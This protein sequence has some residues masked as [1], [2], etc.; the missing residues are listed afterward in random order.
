MAPE[1]ARVG[2]VLPTDG[3]GGGP[4]STPP[5]QRRIRRDRGADPLITDTIMD[6]HE[7]ILTAIGHTP[8]VKLNKLV[9]PNEAMPATD[10]PT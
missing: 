7:N 8:L 3:V 5:G 4:L 1:S 6:I 2:R 10:A 9:G